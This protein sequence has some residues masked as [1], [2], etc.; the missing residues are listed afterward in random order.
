MKSVGFSG[1]HPVRLL[2]RRC[3]SGGRLFSSFLTGRARRAADALRDGPGVPSR[4]ARPPAPRPASPVGLGSGRPVARFSSAGNAPPSAN[5]WLR[6]AS[7]W[8]QGA[9]TPP[10]RRTHAHTRGCGGPPP[11]TSRRVRAP[12]SPRTPRSQ[13]LPHELHAPQPVPGCVAHTQWLPTLVAGGTRRLPRPQRHARGT[14]FFA[15]RHPRHA[16]TRSLAADAW[17]TLR[18]TPTPPERHAR[19]RATGPHPCVSLRVPA[20][21]SAFQ[22]PVHPTSDQPRRSR[23]AHCTALALHCGLQLV[24]HGA[25]ASRKGPARRALTHRPTPGAP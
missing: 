20:L 1:V 15:S 5:L 4:D 17:P 10:A 14:R 18:R 12:L 8:L 9:L 13:P 2:G 16:H 24:A 21:H 3:P 19:R 7:L 6:C 25:E 23:T 11:P 22:P